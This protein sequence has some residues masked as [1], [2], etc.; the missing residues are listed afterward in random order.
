MYFT[1]AGANLNNIGGI[2]YF[3]L[4]DYIGLWLLGRLGWRKLIHLQEKA[5]EEE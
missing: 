5:I 1:A 2:A 3:K 4:T